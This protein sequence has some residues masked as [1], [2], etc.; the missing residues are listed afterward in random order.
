M[1]A[2]WI[3]VTQINISCIDAHLRHVVPLPWSVTSKKRSGFCE[4]EQHEE[5]LSVKKKSSCRWM[6]SPLHAA[7]GL[8]LLN[9]NNLDFPFTCHVCCKCS[10]SLIV[11][12]NWILP[13]FFETAGEWVSNEMLTWKGGGFVQFIWAPGFQFRGA[14]R[15]HHSWV[16]MTAPAH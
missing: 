15:L 6:V 13:V 14:L 11:G 1:S 3:N 2:G 10:V 7:A 5:V 9:I 16:T 12:F 8:W 4:Q